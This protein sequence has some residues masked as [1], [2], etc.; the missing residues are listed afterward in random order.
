MEY[1][2]YG[3]TVRS[4]DAISTTV[5]DWDDFRKFAKV[6]DTIREPSRTLTITEK[7]YESTASG[8][9]FVIHIYAQ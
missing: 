4:A 5:I 9:N 1:Q 7:V 3:N 2:I 8:Q 6:G